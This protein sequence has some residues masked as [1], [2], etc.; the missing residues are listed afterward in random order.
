MVLFLPLPWGLGLILHLCGLQG[1]V[2]LWNI[3]VLAS[4][5]LSILIVTYPWIQT[6]N[7]LQAGPPQCSASKCWVALAG[8]ASERTLQRKYFSTSSRTYISTGI[9]ASTD[10]I[11]GRNR[12]FFFFNSFFWFFF[13]F[14]YFLILLGIWDLSFSVHLDFKVELARRNR[15][16]EGSR[17]IE[18]R[19]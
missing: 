12:F 17:A 10:F 1:L 3:P 5:F 18:Y 16:R 15:N 2:D 13:I 6:V 19:S 7:R 11:G 14:E 9:K 8:F 4:G